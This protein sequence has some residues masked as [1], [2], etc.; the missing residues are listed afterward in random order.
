MAT[1]LE[2]SCAKSSSVPSRIRSLFW[3]CS[4]LLTA[5]KSAPLSASPQR[6]LEPASHSAFQFPS[7]SLLGSQR[8]KRSV[9]LVRPPRR[10][11]A[12]TVRLGEA[13]TDAAT[14]AVEAPPS[15]SDGDTGDDDLASDDDDGEGEDV[16]VG[17]SSSDASVVS[18]LVGPLQSNPAEGV[19][20]APRTSHSPPIYKFDEDGIDVVTL[21]RVDLQRSGEPQ[22]KAATTETEV[23]HH[24]TSGNKVIEGKDDSQTDRQ[25]DRQIDRQVFSYTR[26]CCLSVCLSVCLAGHLLQP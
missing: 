20:L 17:S 24:R 7:R 2:S 9:D 22:W 26:F 11:V 13:D 19:F 21:D 18:S 16:P 12:A 15:E 6:Q 25:T 14:A 5:G 1:T 8:H 3:G 4:L 10:R 23:P